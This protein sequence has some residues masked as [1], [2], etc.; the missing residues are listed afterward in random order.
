MKRLK[1]LE[2]LIVTNIIFSKEATEA[3]IA[4]ALYIFEKT[5]NPN[6][7]DAFLDIMELY[8]TKTLSIFPK[9]GRPAEEFG[10]GVRKLVYQNYSILYRIKDNEIEILT[11]YR[12]NL[13]KI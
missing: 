4:Q 12:E 13:P 8:I 2:R 11:L 5:M 10:E 7:A 9:L 3:L 1:K 6:K